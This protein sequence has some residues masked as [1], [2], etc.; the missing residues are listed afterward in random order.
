M[1]SK[2]ELCKKITDLYPDIG[3]C[4]IDITI[5]YDTEQQVWLV[6]LKKGSHELKHHLEIHDAD[7]CMTDAHCVSLGLDIDQLKKNCAGQ[8]Y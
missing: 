6:D 2:D 4:G 1:Y 3:K 8:Q 5:E 7:A